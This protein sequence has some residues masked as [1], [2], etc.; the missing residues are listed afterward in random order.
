MAVSLKIRRWALPFQFVHS[1]E[2]RDIQLQSCQSPVEDGIVVA[3]K[4]DGRQPL[5]A[6]DQRMPLAPVLRH[7]FQMKVPFKRQRGGFWAPPRQSRKTVRAIAD[8]CE[9]VWNG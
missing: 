5:S 6:P 8:N 2:D 9:V 4:K 7:I 3:L 1:F